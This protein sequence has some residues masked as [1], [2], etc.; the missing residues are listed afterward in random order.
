MLFHQVILAVVEVASL[1]RQR[2]GYHPP[3][4]RREAPHNQRIQQTIPPANK[5]AS[6]LAPD[7][8]RYAKKERHMREIY[9]KQRVVLFG[10]FLLIAGALN[11]AN[12]ENSKFVHFRFGSDVSIDVPRNWYFPDKNIRQ[13]L[14]KDVVHL[15]GVSAVQGNNQILVAANT[16]ALLNSTP[17]S[18][19][20]QLGN[21]DAGKKIRNP[22]RSS[23]IHSHVQW[24]LPFPP[25]SPRQGSSFPTTR[26]VLY[27]TYPTR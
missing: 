24:S 13:H 12:A 19:F 7:P 14:S 5:F 4:A 6:G 20:M 16:R 15:A 3:V 10:V 8:Q 23:S 22:I 11:N 27:A 25:R 2:C 9:T 1:P 21:G 26:P 18:A 17:P